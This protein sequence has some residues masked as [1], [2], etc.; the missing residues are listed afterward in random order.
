MLTQCFRATVL[1]CIST[2]IAGCGG[3]SSSPNSNTTVILQVVPGPWS[4]TYNLGGSSNVPVTGAVSTSGFGYFA[5]KNG[6]V[7]MIENV[8]SQSPFVGTAIGTAP[9]SQTFPDG[10]NVDTFTINGTY[11]STATATSMDASLTGIDPN[12]YTTYAGYKT[13]GVNG[14]FTLNSKVTYQGSL[15][16]GALQGQWSGYYIGLSST[17]ADITINPDGTFDG[18][19]GFGCSIT[20][21]LVQQDP[22]TNLFFV[23][24]KTSGAGCPGFMN[25]LAYISTK[26]ISGGFGNAAGTYLYMGLFSPS[27]AYSVELKL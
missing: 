5:D 12:D 6:Y 2:V 20:G 1:I 23:N 4:G 19:D 14:N 13:T 3:S 16:I 9:P 11:T 15:S 24:Y 26:D 18:N 25:G 10:N 7:F 21:R 22:G 27:V 8:P 17:S